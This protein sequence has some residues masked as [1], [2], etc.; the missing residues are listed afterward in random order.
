MIYGGI[1][2]SPDGSRVAYAAVDPNNYGQAA[3]LRV[4]NVATGQTAVVDA[5]GTSPA[6]SAAGDRLAVLRTNSSSVY[7]GGI[8]GTLVV[9]NPD[10]S[11]QTALTALGSFSPGLTWSPTPERRRDRRRLFPTGLALT[12][13]RA[14]ARDGGPWPCSFEVGPRSRAPRP[15]ARA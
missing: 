14:S 9:S 1:E 5:A 12:W 8:D 13:A 2:V 15:A 6:W 4:L 7:S 11:T 3:G 10:G